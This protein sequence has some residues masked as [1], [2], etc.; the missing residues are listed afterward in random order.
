MRD[1]IFFHL[2]SLTF[3]P[4]HF[5]FAKILSPFQTYN[6]IFFMFSQWAKPYPFT[7]HISQK[8]RSINRGQDVT[9][10]PLNKGFCFRNVKRLFEAGVFILET[11]T[12]DYTAIHGNDIFLLLK[13]YQIKP[14]HFY[15]PEYDVSRLF[16]EN[17][18][19]KLPSICLYFL[20]S[21]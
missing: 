8:S 15:N 20:C 7:R 1:R 17:P 21:L 19:E 13:S 16:K 6:T 11:S 9:N 12:I 2:I 10:L 4:I 14:L 18:L 5:G 3:F